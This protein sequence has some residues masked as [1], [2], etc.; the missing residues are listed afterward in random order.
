MTAERRSC[1]ALAL[2]LA[3]FGCVGPHG[4]VVRVLNESMVSGRRLVVTNVAGAAHAHPVA[5]TPETVKRALDSTG[6]FTGEEARALAPLVAAASS[7]L[8]AENEIVLEAALG[9]KID[10]HIFA[11]A[12]TLRVERW[13][14]STRSSEATFRLPTVLAASPAAAPSGAKPQI[15]VLRLRTE[16]GI[17]ASECNLVSDALVGEVGRLGRFEVIGYGDIQTLLGFEKQKDLLGC[18]E[19]ACIAEVGGALGVERLVGGSIGKIGA[20]VVINLSLVNAV[21]ARAE[22][23]VSRQI[24]G[25][26]EEV[27]K[28]ARPMVEELL[29]SE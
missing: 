16:Q 6:F 12:G 18:G 4:A 7:T 14:G 26:V 5:L 11:Q 22:R 10:I 8:E 25:G 24:S 13:F 3:A 19:V 1:P 21:S 29:R 15:A 23:H 28:I 17:S 9:E 27:F 20:L 2:L